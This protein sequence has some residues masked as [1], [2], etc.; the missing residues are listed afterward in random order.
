MKISTAIKRARNNSY[1]T[2]AI[3]GNVTVMVKTNRGWEEAYTGCAMTARSI[4]RYAVVVDALRLI[5]YEHS[6]AVAAKDAAVRRFAD[7]NTES[8]ACFCINWMA[9]N[10]K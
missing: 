5:G 1:I 8:M 3:N 6:D 7:S 4:R 9:A 10:V 2:D